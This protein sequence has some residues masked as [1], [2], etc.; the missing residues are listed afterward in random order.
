MGSTCVPCLCTISLVFAPVIWSFVDMETRKHTSQY[1]KDGIS[2]ES[3]L[4]DLINKVLEFCNLCDNT[5]AKEELKKARIAE[6][7]EEVD[8]EKQ[9]TKDDSG[10]EGWP[11]VEQLAALRAQ[12]QCHHCK[13]WGHFQNECPSR[14]NKKAD[15]GKGK[16]KADQGKAKGQG[17]GGKTSTPKAPKGGGKGQ[18]KPKGKGPKFGGCFICG[19]PHF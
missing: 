6:P 13:G 1:L 3:D 7:E 17:G 4:S 2:T 18:G 8:E 16:G 19:G 10:Y 15:K 12:A 9:D 14:P 11:D 5:V